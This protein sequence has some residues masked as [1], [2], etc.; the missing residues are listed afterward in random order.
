MGSRNANALEAN[1][2]NQ[3]ANHDP[4]RPMDF[5]AARIWCGLSAIMASSVYPRNDV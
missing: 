1:T 4:V 2:T 5:W 3:A